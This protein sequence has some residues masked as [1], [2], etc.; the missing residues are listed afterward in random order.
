MLIQP[1][2]IS[3]AAVLRIAAGL[4]LLL[5]CAFGY[6]AQ[7]SA[8]HDP[9]RRAGA[10]VNR[11]PDWRENTAEVRVVR[12]ELQPLII[13]AMATLDAPRR[14]EI[15]DGKGA[16]A[17]IYPDIGEPYRSIFSKIIEGIQEQAKVQISTYPVGPNSNA[18]DLS[19]QLVR[20]GVK[21]V[22]A[23]GRQGLKAVSG[24][25][26]EIAV[27]VGGVLSVPESESRN[28][29][30]ISLTPDPAL[31]FALLKRLLPSIKR[32]TVVYDPQHNDWLIKLARE[33]A[34]AQ[35][36]E[37][38]TREA[39][40]LA[41]AAHLYDAAFAVADSRQDAIWLPQDATTVDDETILPLVLKESWS[42]GLPVFSSSFLH[43][44]KGVMFALYPNNL[45]LG[46]DL[47]S[48][49]LGVLSGESRKRGV[50]P[51]REVLTAV[52]LRTASHIG[53][54]LDYQQ[55]RS[56]DFIFPEP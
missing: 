2:R 5:A 43:V 3:F 41:S 6:A 9:G 28:L 31:L 1:R 52:N 4:L 40:D 39:H 8:G 56:F 55:Q 27:V 19:A 21:V 29:T 33:A 36:L 14:Q 50:S 46:R 10:V 44:K 42:R 30:G 7:G 16:I 23:L 18:G 13:A 54:N 11:L 37:L 12:R 53:L 22:I 45:G 24:L 25:T 26:P 35:G 34:K 15:L 38:V 47:A 51:L 48:S 20:G 32:V 49:A 17:V